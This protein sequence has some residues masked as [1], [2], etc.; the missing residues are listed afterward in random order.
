MDYLSINNNHLQVVISLRGAEVHSIFD[1]R[2]QIEYLWQGDQRYWADR[3]PLLFPIIGRL[4]HG[5]YSHDGK[6][7][8]IES[9][10][11]FIKSQ[12][13][14]PTLVMPDRV[15]LQTESTQE[16]KLQYPFAFRFLVEYRLVDAGLVFSFQIENAGDQP[17]PFS[18]GTHSGFRVP[19]L[20]DEKFGDYSL[21]FEYEEN[22]YQVELDGVFLSG[23]TSAFALQSHRFL[24]LRHCLFEHEA[25]ILGGIQK[26]SVSL[27]D[28]AGIARWSLYLDDFDYL[29][30]WQPPQT[31][32]P[33]V[34]LE[35]W[36]GLPDP[37][38]AEID[39][40]SQKPGIQTLV[41]G[42]TAHFSLQI[43]LL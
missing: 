19:L 8:S 22:P 10:H 4:R 24:P 42:K 25:I 28:P 13:F 11:G 21:M 23:K 39:A 32:A 20:N 30:L 41:P 6:T 14:Q 26:K 40:L 29:T 5:V 38:E 15:V 31:D 34:C 9:P 36:N 3:S 7:Y 35:C 12:M 18:L 43:A 1:L 37:D 33:F 2:N 27:I 17:L 16:T